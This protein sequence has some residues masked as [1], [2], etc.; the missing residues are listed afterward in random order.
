[1]PEM[2]FGVVIFCTVAALALSGAVMWIL[3]RKARTSR[4]QI[5]LLSHTFLTGSMLNRAREKAVRQKLGGVFV[6]GDMRTLRLKKKYKLVFIPFNSLQ[7]TYTLRDVEKVFQTVQAHLAPGG[8]FIF[9]IFNPSI[10]YMVKYERLR[11]GVYKFR[12]EDG[13]KVTIDQICRYDSMGQVNRATWIHH[14]D[15]GKPMARKLDMR[16]F[17]PQE[18]EAILKYNGFKIIGKFGDFNKK[19]FS[20]E[21]LK[22]IFICKKG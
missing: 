10:Q 5:A 14:I 22:Q 8:R 12:L 9:D 13:R 7:N 6:K 3:A 4:R 2:T 15:G 16:C 1:M 18:M 11:K 21:A 19:P 20:S 17:Y